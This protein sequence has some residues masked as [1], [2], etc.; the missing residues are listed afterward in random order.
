MTKN[1]FIKKAKEIYGDKYSYRSVN[2]THLEPYN[3]I[4]IH[5]DIHGLFFQ[6]V[7]DHLQGK[8]CYECGIEKEDEE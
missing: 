4:P 3:N 1:D 8:G 5:C 6:S 2:D 7:Y